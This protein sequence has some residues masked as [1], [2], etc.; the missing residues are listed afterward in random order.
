M[1]AYSVD[2]RVL[3]LEIHSDLMMVARMERQKAASMVEMMAN[4][5]V[6]L[7]GHRRVDVMVGVMVLSWVVCLVGVMVDSKAEVTDIVLAALRVACLVDSM[8][9]QRDK[10]LVYK[11]VGMKAQMMAVTMVT[12]MENYLVAW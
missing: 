5:W 7:L 12:M 3:L 8:V 4:Y 6:E 1:V 10:H 9:Y 2:W 11:M